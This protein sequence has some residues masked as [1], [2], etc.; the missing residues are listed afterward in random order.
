[1]VYRRSCSAV[2]AYSGSGRWGTQCVLT[3]TAMLRRTP[4]HRA[5]YWGNIGAVARLLEAGASVHVAD[6]KVPS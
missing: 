2:V 1:M 3:G 4:L 6:H 5:L